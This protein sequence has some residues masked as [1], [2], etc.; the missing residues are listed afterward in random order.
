MFTTTLGCTYLGAA[1]CYVG[2]S[3]STPAV[4]AAMR[5]AVSPVWV[6]AGGFLLLAVGL[7]IAVGTRPV[8]E[9]ILVWLSMAIATC[10]LL[11]VA[12][13]LVDRFVPVTAVLAVLIAGGGLWL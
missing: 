8:A 12:A 9:G 2:A 1:L 5:A 6:R 11:V 7:V 4:G 13:P 3:S 10:S